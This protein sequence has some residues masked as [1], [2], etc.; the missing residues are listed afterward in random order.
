MHRSYTQETLLHLSFQYLLKP[1]LAS[2][3]PS[4]F[5]DL[6]NPLMSWKDPTLHYIDTIKV[7]IWKTLG[8]WGLQNISNKWKSDC[9]WKQHVRTAPVMNDLYL[10]LICSLFL[11]LP[12]LLLLISPPPSILSPHPVRTG[13]CTWWLTYAISQTGAHDGETAGNMQLHKLCLQYSSRL[14]LR[15][16]LLCITEYFINALAE[17]EM[18]GMRGFYPSFYSC[19]R[20]WT[21]KRKHE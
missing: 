13:P 2:S 6:R 18:R 9:N 17:S 16:G 8:V 14:K 11:S 21:V 3:Q 12:F 15:L 7:A 20:E 5:N 19:R 1:T 10:H 4:V